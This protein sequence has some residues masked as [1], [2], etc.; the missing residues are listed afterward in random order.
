MMYDLHFTRLVL[1]IQLAVANFSAYF[2]YY[3]DSTKDDVKNRVDCDQ[4]CEKAYSKC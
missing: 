1:P 4:L 3:D 2:K